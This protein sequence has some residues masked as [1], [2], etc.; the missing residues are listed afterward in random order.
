MFS[1]QNALLVPNCLGG[2]GTCGVSSY[3]PNTDELDAYLCSS[4]TDPYTLHY[5]DAQEADLTVLS[6]TKVV[7]QWSAFHPAGGAAHTQRLD[8]GR[9]T[10][11]WVSWDVVDNAGKP[12]PM[13]DYVVRATFFAREVD[14]RTVD[15]TFTVS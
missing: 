13:G 14:Q 7:W 9:C 5:A 10:H 15:S 2:P 4:S 1:Q 8:S 6:G 12:L 11:W 3:D